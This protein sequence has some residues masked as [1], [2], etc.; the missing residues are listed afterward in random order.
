[1]ALTK[2]T[3]GVRTIASSEVVTASIAD[4]AVTLAKMAP[5]T[6]G[7]LISYDASGNPAAV[8]TGSSGQ[9][10]T[11]QGAGAAPVF[12]TAAATITEGSETATTS[13]TSIDFSSIPSGV[14]IIRVGFIGVSTNSTSNWLIQIGDSG[15]LE[16]SGYSSQASV[17][18]SSSSSTVGFVLTSALNAAA[19]VGGIVELMRVD[20]GGTKWVYTSRLAVAAFHPH[21]GAGYKTLT[22]ELDRLRLTTTNGSDT[23]DAGSVNIQYA[24]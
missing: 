18:A 5:G 2:V 4:D 22:A 23:F 7:N 6:D 14:K 16:T 9:I 3:S 15:G 19:A 13:G 24:G 17:A 21:G 10:L 8:A 12:A 20:S 11:S 1:M